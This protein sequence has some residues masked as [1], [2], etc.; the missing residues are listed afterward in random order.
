ME[1]VDIVVFKRNT[2][3]KGTVSRLRKEGFVPAVI[4]GK[5]INLSVKVPSDQVKILKSI[6][7]SESVLVNI[8]VKESLEGEDIEQVSTVIRDIQYHPLTEKVI[9]IDF[10]KVSLEEKMRVNVP[11]ILK[12]EPVGLKEGGVLE[13]II[14]EIEVEGR[15]SDI[16]PHIEV[17][18]SELHINHS[19]HV[20][21]IKLPENLTVLTEL[22]DTVVTIVGMEKEE[23]VVEA[24][25]GQEMEPE[26]VKEKS[27]EKAEEDKEE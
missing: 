18:I 11:V 25:E 13:Q 4:Y 15:F 12:G 1:K 22:E 16:P 24:L 20:K 26:V 17:D 19:I 2:Y 21:D 27:K 6:H 10:M 7:F 23:E 3:G 9:H 5:E 14:R 8:R